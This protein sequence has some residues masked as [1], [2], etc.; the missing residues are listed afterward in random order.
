[1]M[2][3]QLSSVHQTVLLTAIFL[4]MLT[5]VFLVCVSAAD[6]RGRPNAV[7]AVILF[8]V[9]FLLEE[10]LCEQAAHAE[11]TPVP[12]WALWV[13]TAGAD[14]WLIFALVKWRRDMR[15]SIS[16][17]SI[18]RAMDAVPAAVCFFAP[19]GE[20]KLCNPQMYALFRDIAQR[21][22]QSFDEFSQALERCTGDAGVIRDTTDADTFIFPNGRVWHYSCSEISLSD[23]KTYTEILFT[24]ITELHEKRRELDRQ[25]AELKEIYT[26]LKRLSDNVIEMT[27]EKEILIA[28]T[29]L[30]DNMGVGIAAVRQILL[31]NNASE[32]NA[33]ALELWRKAIRIIKSDN[34][35]PDG[36]RDTADIIHDAAAVGIRVEIT[37]E[38]PTEGETGRLM[39]LAIRECL[40]NA[41][42][43]AGAT[44]LRIS[45]TK[46]ADAVTLRISNDGKPA[47]GDMT[48][49]GGLKNLS[50]Q[51]AECG[52]SMDI[53]TEPE[54]MLTVTIP[55][56][57]EV[58]V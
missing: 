41:A 28:K 50:W 9:M 6:K 7:I 57:M 35:Y 30:H 43:H 4:T 5:A 21:D 44:T 54:Y 11:G 40:S 10:T 36:C 53:R 12:A 17:F 16:L 27:R 47:S 46:T 33:A 52:G 24:D 58:S 45:L 19:S 18:K 31:Q 55:T 13:L 29:R 3:Y 38:I 39:L 34:E 56:G 42:N 22:L 51:L 25:S 2:F 26:D 14:V 49:R 8:L 32:E 15:A 1:M 20:I 23:G 37:G 48:P